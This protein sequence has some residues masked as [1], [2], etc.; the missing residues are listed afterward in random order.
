MASQ[1]GT[2]RASAERTGLSVTT[3]I[4]ASRIGPSSPLAAR[5]PAITTTS[6]A[7]PK[8]ARVTPGPSLAAF[9]GPSETFHR[10]PA[11][12]GGGRTNGWR[13]P[14]TPMCRI[15]L[16]Y[17]VAEVDRLDRVGMGSLAPPR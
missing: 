12:S 6:A 11:Y 1:P 3:R 10:V 15:P 9:M 4:S 14:L 17:D 2:W 16:V 5:M 7:V 8:R 13:W